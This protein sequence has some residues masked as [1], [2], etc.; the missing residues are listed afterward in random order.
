M[1]IV[2]R[3]IATPFSGICN[4]NSEDRRIGEKAPYHARMHLTHWPRMLSV[5][6]FED[7]TQTSEI[8]PFSEVNIFE[9]VV[10]CIRNDID[11]VWSTSGFPA[12]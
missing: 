4:H 8:D 6:S 3:K 11:S 7:G 5:C 12:P 10:T 9:V 1:H 2:D